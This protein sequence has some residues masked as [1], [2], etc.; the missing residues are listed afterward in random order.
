MNILLQN[1]SEPL[2]SFYSTTENLT[3]FIWEEMQKAL[4]HTSV[5]LFEVVVHETEKNTF[6]YRGE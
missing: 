1:V 5:S 3:V 6:L 2:L 4:T